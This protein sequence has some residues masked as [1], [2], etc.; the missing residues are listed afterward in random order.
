MSN[1]YNKMTFLSPALGI[2]FGAGAGLFAALLVKGNLAISMISGAALG[3]VAGIIIYS[4]IR[5][6]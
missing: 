3:V 4:F 2:I 6:R 5:K 1:N